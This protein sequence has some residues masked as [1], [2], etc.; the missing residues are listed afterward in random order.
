MKFVHC[1]DVSELIIDK[2]DLK[3]TEVYIRC[4]YLKSIFK[5]L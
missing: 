1:I 2:L 5:E 3:T 4:E